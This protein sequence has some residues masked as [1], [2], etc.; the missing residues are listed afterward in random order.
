MNHIKRVITL[1]LLLALVVCFECASAE[2]LTSSQKQDLFNKTLSEL[3]AYL[4]EL[5]EDPARLNSIA[6]R[7][8]E[9]GGIPQSRQFWYYVNVLLKVATGEFDFE[10]E[11]SLFILTQ[12]ASFSQFLDKLDNS[13]I[14][15]VEKLT[16]Y[17]NARRAERDSNTEA[18]LEYYLECM[19]FFD[20]T[21]RYDTLLGQNL[22]TLYERGS[23]YLRGNN[24]AAAYWAFQS[25]GNYSDAAERANAVI[26]MIGYIPE[27]ELDNPGSVQSV[28]LFE[29]GDTYVSLIWNMPAHATSYTVEYRLSGESAWKLAGSTANIICKVTGLTV[30][31]LYDFRVTAC[32]ASFK[33]EGALL[34]NVLTAASAPTPVPTP[35]PTPAPAFAVGD[36]F[37]FGSY[38]QDDDKKNGKEPI[39]WIVISVNEDGS[40]VLLSKYALDMKDLEYASV[41]N[42]TWENSSLRKWLNGS[43]YEE[44]FSTAEKAKIMTTKV[45]NEDHPIN[46]LP[47]GSD[48]FDKVWLL[49]ASE[50]CDTFGKDKQYSYFKDDT[51]RKCLSTQYA[52]TQGLIKRYGVKGMSECGWWLRSPYNGF[53]FADY[54]TAKGTVMF[55]NNILITMTNT[56]VR[57]VIAVTP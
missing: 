57:P 9:L 5:K 41:L 24:P 40:L 50:V 54:V 49:S 21:D 7:F 14:G 55:Q 33:T 53:Y 39:D 18:A 29:T 10:L 43:F 26:A 6:L 34:E 22:R 25:A 19:D 2:V 52:S 12:T 35:S 32:A 56:A 44:A 4:S 51:S 46:G 23:T 13:P 36:I 37:T 3:E 16:A 20:S 15:S 27:N 48:T 30:N 8:Y 31:S 11:N 42:T 1:C 28:M 17:V 45:E 38:E 47:G